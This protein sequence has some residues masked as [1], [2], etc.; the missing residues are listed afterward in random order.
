VVAIREDD[1]VTVDIDPREPL[2]KESK[3]IVIANTG[4]LAKLK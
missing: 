4:K 3:L 2:R 1:M